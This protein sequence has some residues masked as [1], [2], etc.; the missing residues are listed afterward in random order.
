MELVVPLPF[1]LALRDPPGGGG[2]AR[3]R[4][5][6]ARARGPDDVGGAGREV[7]KVATVEGANDGVARE[8]HGGDCMKVVDGGC[9]LMY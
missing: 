4:T 7:G 9:R 6:V 3:E 2:N 1:D 8:S 5:G